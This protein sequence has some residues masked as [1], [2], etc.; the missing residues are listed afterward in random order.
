MDT[1]WLQKA[2]EAITNG[3]ADKLEKGNIKV[4]RVGAG[5]IRIDIKEN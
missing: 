5:L 1:E 3:I 4:Y 2:I